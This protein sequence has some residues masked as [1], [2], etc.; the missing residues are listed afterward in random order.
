MK[1]S[2][3]LTLVVLVALALVSC[4]GSEVGPPLIGSGLIFATETPGPTP[5]AEATL[6]PAPS[7]TAG[8][9]PTAEGPTPTATR[10]TFALG[11]P[12]VLPTLT[13]TAESAEA[14][15]GDGAFTPEA[16]KQF[17][18]VA[19]TFANTTGLAVPLAVSQQT[20]VRDALGRAYTMDRSATAL[21]AERQ[22]DTLVPA[23]S[24]IRGA[25]GYQVPVDATGLQWTFNDG[26]TTVAFNL[27]ADMTVPAGATATAEETAT[28]GASET[29]SPGYL[30]GSSGT[31][32]GLVV[33]LEEV[34]SSAGSSTIR[35]AGGSRFILIRAS[36]TNTTQDGMLVSS[37]LQTELRDAADRRYPPDVMG[38]ALMATEGGSPDG[39]AAPGATVSGWIGYQAPENAAGLRWVFKTV[40]G[41]D[42]ITFPI[43]GLP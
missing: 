23:R 33:T 21:A 22:P 14:S 18:I 27:P 30:S 34:R 42:S 31:L 9:T 37:L 39:V 16:G 4:G 40:D 3:L 28:V 24:E 7:P 15:S 19:A 41:T 2:V 38:T 35:P 10:T 12:A 25:M 6:T 43:E 5:T 32:A 36:V 8:P 20:A 1:A 26:T 17:V 29:P 11:E 13:I